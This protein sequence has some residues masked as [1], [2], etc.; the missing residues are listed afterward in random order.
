ML[1]TH[2]SP[3]SETPAQP[4]YLE[5]LQAREHITT[6]FSFIVFTFGLAFEFF[7]EFGGASKLILS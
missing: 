7:K 4:F 2:P 5:M 3:Q 1:V 6:S